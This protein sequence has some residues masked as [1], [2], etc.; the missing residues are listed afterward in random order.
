VAIDYSREDSV[1]VTLQGEIPVKKVGLTFGLEVSAALRAQ[2]SVKGTVTWDIS[3]KTS[4]T[5]EVGYG[6]DDGAS[7]K[8]TLTFRF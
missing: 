3:K 7:A 4:M 1:R 8:A 2:E 6:T 5:A